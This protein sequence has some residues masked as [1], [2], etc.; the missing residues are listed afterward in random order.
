TTNF[1]SDSPRVVIDRPVFPVGNNTFN[2]VSERDYFLPNPPDGLTCTT[3]S[4]ASL[5]RWRR[6]RGGWVLQ[7]IDWTDVGLASGWKQ[8]S[9]GN[10]GQM[11]LK[12]GLVKG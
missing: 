1:T 8:G 4:G 11:Q 5:K 7:N 6:E 10:Y 2:S 9:V 12:D 3:G